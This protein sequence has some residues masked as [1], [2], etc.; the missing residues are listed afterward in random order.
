M[1]FINNLSEIAN[2]RI[3]DRRIT[4]FEQFDHFVG[5]F[6]GIG[7]KHERRQTRIT[8]AVDAQIGERFIFEQRKIPI[9]ASV[10][11]RFLDERVKRQ[12]AHSVGRGFVF[13]HIFQFVAVAFDVA[14]RIGL[15]RVQIKRPTRQNRRNFLR[16]VII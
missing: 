1:L 15:K 11:I 9:V 3:A 5:V 6:F 12:I 8:R 10:P 7:I 4:A 14:E 13:N 2:R 16:S